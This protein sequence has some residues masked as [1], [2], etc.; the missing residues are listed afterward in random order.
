MHASLG[1]LL[2]LLL[3]RGF[4]GFDEGLPKLVNSSNL[5]WAQSIFGHVSPNRRAIE[6]IFDPS[7]INGQ[8]IVRRSDFG[9][10]LWTVI[11]RWTSRLAHI[12]RASCMS[13]DANV[14][15]LPG[16]ENNGAIVNRATT[17]KWE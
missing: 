12:R 6:R 5:W 15:A 13:A 11:L 8:H 9:L 16:L 4:F 3:V 17:D 10:Y 2:L 1:I 14:S 7:A